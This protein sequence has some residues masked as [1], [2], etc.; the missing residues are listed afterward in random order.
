LTVLDSDSE[1]KIKKVESEKD[2]RIKQL[3]SDQDKW[4]K[5]ADM[6]ILKSSVSQSK[7]SAI[8]QLY[9]KQEE[10]NMK[11]QMKVKNDLHVMELKKWR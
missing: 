6:H 1:C 10:L 3:E 5:K 4:Q 11:Y 9:L 7:P 2:R 8:D